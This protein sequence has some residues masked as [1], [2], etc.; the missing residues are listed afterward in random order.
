MLTQADENKAEDDGASR[1]RQLGDAAERPKQTE[2]DIHHTRTHRDP[3]QGIAPNSSI[4]QS[5]KDSIEF[6]I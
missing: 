5:R 6:Q 4:V 3:E 1:G 2:A